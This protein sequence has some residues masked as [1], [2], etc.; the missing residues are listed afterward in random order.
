[1]SMLARGIVQDLREREPSRVVNAKIAEGMQANADLPLLRIALENLLSNAWK[2]TGR[3]ARGE[4]EVGMINGGGERTYLVRDN[5]AGFDMAAAGRLFG[6]FERLHSE[7]EFPG[8]GIG[9]TTVQRI[10]R[11]HG[12]NIRAESAKGGGTTF[13]FDLGLADQKE[14]K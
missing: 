5:G 10:I 2:F 8:T 11:R 14:A 12:G 4:I 3:T 9:L 7:A 6:A 1:M 13:F